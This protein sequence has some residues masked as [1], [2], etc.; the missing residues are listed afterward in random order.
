MLRL[1]LHLTLRTGREGLVRLLVTAAA[2]GV[3]VGLLLSVLAMFHA[4]QS[5]V[6]RPCW[7]CTYQTSDSG[8]L[9]WNYSEDNYGGSTVERL[10]VAVLAPDAPSIPGL[11]QLPAAGRYYVSPALARLL[12]TV[13]SGQLGARYPGTPAGTIGEAALQNPDALVI[14]VGRTA[15]QMRALPRTVRVDA[16]QTDPRG[17]GTSPFYQFGFA[18]GTVALL[19]PIAVLIGNAARIAAA[20]REERYAAMRLVG[21]TRGQITIAASTEAVVGALAGGALGLGCYAL[22]R[23]ALTHIP[24]LGFAFFPDRITPTGWAIA[25]VLAGAPIAAALACLASLRRVGIEPLGVARRATPPAPRIWRV[26]PLVVALGV[27]C[28]PLTMDPAIQRKNPNLAVG[29]LLA[30]MAG[31]LIAGPWLAAASARLLARRAGSGPRLLAARRLADNPRAA[32]RAVSGLVLAVMIGTALAA[33]VP[34]AVSSEASPGDGAL[35]DV[36]RVGFDNGNRLNQH[37]GEEQTGLT[38]DAAAPLLHSIA[39]VPGTTLIPLYHPSR[40]DD[41]LPRVGPSLGGETVLRCADLQALPALGACRP[42]AATALIDAGALYTDNIAALNNVLPFVTSTSPVT[43]DDPGRLTL[44]DLMVV[45]RDAT[46]LERVRTVL[47]QY[48]GLIDPGESAMTFGEVSAARTRI[49]Q[50]LQRVVTVIAALTMLIAGSGLAV[51][52]ASSLVERKRSFTLLRVSGTG[53][54]VLYRAVLLEAALPLLLATVVAAVVG[55]VVA[56]PIAR[57][58]APD[59]H[60]FPL[61]DSAYYA[62]LGA[63]LAGALL[64]IASCLPVLGR[65]TAPH[66]ARFE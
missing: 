28:L 8:R 59:R 51:T 21:A 54:G 20:R 9:L 30:V 50:E 45:T 44:S 24:L 18:L 15:G 3:G 1:A 10:D 19:V 48:S 26:V 12:T 58:L 27:F 11:A 49:Y 47:S 55:L 42:G 35:N 43:H 36:L 65:I 2:V 40:A 7:E 61:P 31:V 4:Y 37:P 39:A 56:L 62:L 38:P 22:L 46:A 6:S 66:N 57:I 60:A 16:V 41:A 64:I 52:I 23:P 29:G 53:V 13:S 34:A 14:V 5:T 25:A 33:L 32:F 63:S 17:L